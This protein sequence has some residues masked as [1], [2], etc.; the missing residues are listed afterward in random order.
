MARTTLIRV[1]RVQMTGIFFLLILAV[2]V[3][4]QPPTAQGGPKY[5][6]DP[7]WPKPLPA[8]KDTQGQT[9]QWVTGDVGASCVR[10]LRCW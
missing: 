1:G 7:A 9:H 3:W 10:Y 4:Q 6:V 2:G 8:P 5:E